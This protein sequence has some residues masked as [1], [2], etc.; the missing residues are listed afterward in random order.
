MPLTDHLLR[1][2]PNNYLSIAIW[3]FAFLVALYLS[4]KFFHQV[5]NAV[6]RVI[7]NAMRLTA[8][9]V[10]IAENRL[11]K[12]NREILLAKG[13]EIAE[14]KVEREFDHINTAVVRNLEGYPTLHHK[15]SEIITNLEEDHTRS[16]NVPPSLP[17]WTPIIDAIA[18][19][20]H[21]GD[22]M[23]STTLLEIKR[24]LQKQHTAAIESYRNSI[25]KRHAILNKMLPLWRKLQKILGGMGKSVT[26]LNERAKSIDRYM[27]EYEQIKLKTDK[28]ERMLS[29][30]VL[31]QFFVSGLILLVGV[32]AAVI[33]FHLI[34]LPMSEM[35]G[36]G[37]YIGPYKTS[38][39]AGIV[40]TL[41]VFT[42]GLFLMESLRITRLFPI[43]GGMDGKMRYRMIWITLSL[44]MVFAGVESVL[45]LLRD[46]M[47]AD[48]ESLRQMLAGV[49]Q[50]TVPNSI[51]PTISQMVL[52]FIIPFAL[53]FVAIPLEFFISSSRTVLGIILAGILRFIAFFLRLM[54]NIVVYAGKVIITVYDLFIFPTLWLEGVLT[55]SPQKVKRSPGTG[56]G[57]GFFKSRKSDQTQK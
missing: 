11:M 49:E 9:S 29:S 3:I 28:A 24:T 54:G 56:T 45:A 33:N 10:L 53:A 21:S 23:V 6:G 40:I 34:A 20:E 7:N 51:I 12:R 2:T 38:D 36:G 16:I 47:T 22:S 50:T 32:G 55:G 57:F 19:I 27:D 8:A 1:I 48:M 26:M 25:K 39:V 52:G 13:L 43:I 37:N 14:R 17:D 44:L 42:M 5:I 35:V 41:V 18:K 4:R 30:S 15:I 46:R 31:T